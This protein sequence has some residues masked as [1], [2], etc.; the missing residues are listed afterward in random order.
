M[1]G[2][3]SYRLGVD[4]GTSTT[5]AM[6]RWPDG[7]IRPLLFDGSPLL[8]SAVFLGPDGQLHTGRDAAHLARGN[9][10]RLE[11]NPKRRIDDG[12]TVLGGVEVPVRELLTAVLRRVGD[13]AAR[14][15]GP[16]GDLTLTH[17]A[18]WGARRRE[19]LADAASRAGLPRPRL[20]GEPEAAATYLMGTL[21][22]RVDPGTRVLVYD[23]GAGTCDLT[24]LRR[25]HSGF[26]VVA[27]AGLNDVGGLDV[28]A[29]LVGFL[30]A[31]Y[32]RLSTDA[33][34]R[35]DLWAEVS[36]AK[37]MLSRA[38]G[39]MI[40][41]AQRRLEVPL[42]REQFD[43]L[44]APVLRPTIALATS[45]LR[46]TATSSNPATQ[47]VLVG[48]ASRIPL[49]ATLLTTALGVAPI[50]VEQPEL[51]VAEGALH[52]FPDR[53]ASGLPTAS[54]TGRPVS[55]RPGP[56]V[57]PVVGP[58]TGPVVGPPTAPVGFGSQADLIDLGVAADR[59]GSGRPVRRSR[60]LMGAALTAVLLVLVLGVVGWRY[61]Q[62]RWL[63]G[64]TLLGAG[65]TPGT[66]TPSTGVSPQPAARYKV[67]QLPEN[68]CGKIDLGP[69]A[70]RFGQDVTAPVYQRNLTTVVGTASCTISRQRQGQTL[71]SLTATAFVYT[72]PSFAVTTQRQVLDNAELNDSDVRAVD[73]IGQEAFLSKV[74]G[75]SAT[76]AQTAG[77]A[78]EIRDANLRWTIYFIATKITGSGWTATERT[79]LIRD[80]ESSI[81]TSHARLIAG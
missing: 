10:E 59:T 54:M 21:G 9:P 73:G 39:T 15:A 36:N 55:P 66:S 27:S 20:V 67:T 38:S 63:T 29:A 74:P 19:L 2:P 8:S 60:G 76:T 50:V 28:D 31:T 45:L 79:D 49:V 23:L 65:R 62:G 46:D 52:T 12:A 26:A 72:D 13:E 81:R 58:P 78:L 22:T 14:V 53:T 7:R 11:P 42:G 37:E 70:T 80:F 3:A 44:V 61:A 33:A 6:L 48:G 40:T 25:E 68:L 35:R 24:V 56:P 4:L 16:I 64:D 57:G 34:S 47:V 43:N 17:P 75:N 32:G 5:V 69:L 77:Y 41:I 71:L 30:E 51:V 1:T 18:A